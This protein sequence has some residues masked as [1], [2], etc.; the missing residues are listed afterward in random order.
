MYGI[1]VLLACHVCFCIHGVDSL[2]AGTTTTTRRKLL[3]DLATTT[4]G[5]VT[6][7]TITTPRSTWA[8]DT[9]F[10]ISKYPFRYSD[11]WTG[12]LLPRLDLAQSVDRAKGDETWPMG[13]WPDPALRIPAEP[14]AEEW[15]GTDTLNRACDLLTQTA[16]HNGAVGLAAQQCGVNARIVVLEKEKGLRGQLKQHKDNASKNDFI[17]MVNPK[18]IRRSPE[19]EARVWNERC[20]VLPPN[21]VATVLRDAVVDVQYQTA[22]DDDGAVHVMRLTGETARAMQHEL[23]H[24]RG[25][26]VTD[27]VGLSDLPDAVMRQIEQ[28]GHDERMGRAFDRYVYEAN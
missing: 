15:F 19:I 21:F 3:H 7:A 28:A 24:D 10:D 20:L 14:V 25:I 8:V 4:V 5:M 1:S 26:L 16:R 13:R 18:I 23:D 27:H 9:D 17:V 11:E 22:Q 12:T 2:S 6:T